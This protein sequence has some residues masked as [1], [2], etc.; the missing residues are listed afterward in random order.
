MLGDSLV[1]TR[2]SELLISEVWM[3]D[4]RLDQLCRTEHPL[5]CNSSTDAVWLSPNGAII[6]STHGD[7]DFYVTCGDGYITLN[8]YS[9][10]T[11]ACSWIIL[12]Y[13]A[14]EWRLL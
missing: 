8:H 2:N 3:R 1:V 13:T 7:G 5:C 4:D 9:Y 10:T 12:L 6:S 11:T 14:S